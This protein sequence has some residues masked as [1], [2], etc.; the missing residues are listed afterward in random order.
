MKIPVKLLKAAG[1]TILSYWR[2]AVLIAAVAGSAWVSHRL[3]AFSYEQRE[4]AYAEQ[5]R[6]DQ[7]DAQARVNALSLE[8]A[9]ERREARRSWQP[10]TKEVIK[11]VSDP[12]VKR[13]NFDDQR[14]QLKTRILAA[15]DSAG[16]ATDSPVQSGDTS[17]GQ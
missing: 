4:A 5:V 7:D 11:Y 10:V 3:T 12:T 9:H 2:P 8:L 17:S 14:V 13:C 16:G 15:A 1:S 6:K